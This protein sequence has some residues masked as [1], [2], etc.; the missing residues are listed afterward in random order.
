V[1]HLWSGASPLNQ[2]P[3]QM[4]CTGLANFTSKCSCT[5]ARNLIVSFQLMGFCCD[6]RP[7]RRQ[8]AEESFPQEKPRTAYRYM[9]CVLR[10]HAFITL[11]DC[12]RPSL[13]SLSLSLLSL[14]C[15]VFFLV[16]LLHIDTHSGYHCTDLKHASSPASS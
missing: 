3:K 14:S 16:T 10:A 8:R 13:S 9:F 6:R 1:V 12:P 7:R 5:L 2:V 4:N 15:F 11:V